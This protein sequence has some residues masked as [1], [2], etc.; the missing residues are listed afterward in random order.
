MSFIE[1]GGSRC[2]IHVVGD[3]L[4][5]QHSRKTLYGGVTLFGCLTLLVWKLRLMPLKNKRHKGTVIGVE[6]TRAKQKLHGSQG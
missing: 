5:A 4:E 1:K 3:R 2:M 6:S